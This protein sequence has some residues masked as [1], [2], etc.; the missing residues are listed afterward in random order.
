MDFYSYEKSLPAS[1]KKALGIIY[2]PP[3]IVNYINTKL[4]DSWKA[5][6]PPRVIDFSCGTGVF[7]HDMAEKIAT[8]YDIS[9]GDVIAKYIYGADIDRRAAQIC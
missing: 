2:T 9:Y 1:K 5:P 7:L 4:L 6:H 3:E 8:R